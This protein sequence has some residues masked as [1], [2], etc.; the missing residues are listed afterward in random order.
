MLARLQQ[1]TTLSLLAAAALWAV[2]FYRAGHPAWAG[3]GVLLIVFGYALFLAMEFMLLWR[4][5]GDDPAPRA[6]GAQLLKAWFSETHTSAGNS[7]SGHGFCLITCPP[8]T[9]AVGLC[10]CMASSATAD[11]GIAGCC[12]FANKMCRSSP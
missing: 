8:P 5:H 7:R 4:V 1:F 12:G 3:L 9:A 11:C 10:S 2:L 6:T